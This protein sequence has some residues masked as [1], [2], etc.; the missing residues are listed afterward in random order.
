M[1]DSPPKIVP[2]AADFHEDLVQV[3]L[4]LRAAP[5][6]LRTLFPD[7]MSEVSPEP[8]DPEADAFVAD[9][10]AALV[11]QVLDIAK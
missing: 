11:E 8:I 10:Y 4:P 7:L 5:H 1:V 2:L 6:G 9:I 3:P